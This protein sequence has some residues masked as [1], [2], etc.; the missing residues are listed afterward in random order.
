MTDKTLELAVDLTKSAMTPTTR[1]WLGSP[2][3]VAKFLEAIAKK[4]H[5][6]ASQA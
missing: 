2:E 3:E 5:E 4:I 6:L 1:A